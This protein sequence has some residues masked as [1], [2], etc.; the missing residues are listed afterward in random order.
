MIE[1][2]IVLGTIGGILG[3]LLSIASIYLKVEIDHREDYI[4]TKLAGANCGVCGYPGCQ[5]YA[6]AIVSEEVD[7]LSACLPTKKHSKEDI[8]EYLKNTPGPDGKSIHIKR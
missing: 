1:A 5:A 6:K 3:L 7:N 8:K 2:V 4:L